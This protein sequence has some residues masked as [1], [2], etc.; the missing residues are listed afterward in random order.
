MKPSQDSKYGKPDFLLHKNPLPEETF[1]TIPAKGGKSPEQERLL[2]RREFLK[3]LGVAGAGALVA[4]CEAC[5]FCPC[6]IN[7]VCAG[8]APGV[9][10]TPT[11]TPSLTPSPTS[12]LTPSPTPSPTPTQINSS[13]FYK[14]LENLQSYCP[15]FTVPQICPCDTFSVCSCVVEPPPCGCIGYSICSCISF[16]PCGCVTYF[17]CT[18]MP[19]CTAT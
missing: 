7:F 16:N 13:E 3:V 2:G 12:S 18:C 5:Q 6:V 1:K 11:T 15:P 10:S 17:P 8:V 14:T 4:A 9:N 19:F